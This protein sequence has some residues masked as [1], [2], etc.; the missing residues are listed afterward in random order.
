MITLTYEDG[1]VQKS[2]DLL[3]D[4]FA[5]LRPVMARFTKY[6]RAEL[7]QVF[8]SQGG[9]AWPGRSPAGEQ[10]LDGMKAAKI[11]KIR[12]AQYNSLRGSLR[13]EK[14][15]AERRLAKTPQ[16]SSKL[17]EKRRASVAKYE[18]MQAELER[19]AAGGA[20]TDDKAYRKLYGRIGRR[21]D[22][23]QKKIEAVE[24]GQLLGAV[25]NS[26][27]AKF[28]KSN[29]EMFS[30]IPWAGIHNSGGTAG[31]G[32]NIPA[33]VFLEWTPARIEKFVQM[34]NE[35]VLSRA[36]KAGGKGSK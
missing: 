4:S 35:Y 34:A 8:S 23:A 28:D 26:I 12:A 32:A 3:A 5:E 36:A 18:G 2:L 1:G 25:A 11:E 7:D 29:W 20:K 24:S 17:T 30:S 21:E 15:K 10:R 6:M 33:R 19:Y 27:S 22:R 31:N 14:R 13:T 9:G 16:S